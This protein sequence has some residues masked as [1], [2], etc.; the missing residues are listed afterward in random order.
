MDKNFQDRIDE[1]L[2][3]S[4]LMSEAAKMQFQKEIEEDAEKKEQYEFTKNVRNA[5]ASRGEKLKAIVEFEKA[6]KK[7][8]RRKI[9]LGVSSVAAVLVVGFLTINPLL[10]DDSQDGSV[11]GG[12]E[13][14]E[15][16]LPV[17]DEPKRNCPNYKSRHDTTKVRKDSVT[18]QCK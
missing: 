15:K 6:M 2:L 3:R 10:V 13:V 16:E 17:V 8:K 14:F 11:R 4:D 18:M 9:W 1:Y 12:E 7:S 5:M